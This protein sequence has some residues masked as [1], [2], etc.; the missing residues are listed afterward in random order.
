MDKER[1]R[2]GKVYITATNPQDAESRIVQ[3]ARDGVTD[4]ICVSNMRTVVLANEDKEYCKLMNEAFMCLPDGMP[5]TWMARLWGR[6][7]VNRTDGPDL[8]VSM[9]NKPEYGL[10]HFL[11]GDTEETL[12]AMMEKYP[13]AGIVDTY[14]PPFKPLEEYDLQALADRI[15]ESGANIVWVS[16]R[17]PKQDILAQRLK[18]L[19]K[20]K[21]CIGVG[22]AFRFALGNYKH[23]N[24]VVQKMGLTG[25]FWRKI[26]FK[27]LLTYCKW[28]MLCTWWGGQFCAPAY[29][30]CL[31]NNNLCYAVR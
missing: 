24:K 15:N 6:R 10:K 3:A 21:L 26:G 18:P 17:A 14:S 5:L 25:F 16:L 7:D 9:L 11:L 8:M 20:N 29:A 13:D 12:A 22:A 30:A 19:L 2:I 23:P 31:R 27:G 28:V 4:Y 1:Y